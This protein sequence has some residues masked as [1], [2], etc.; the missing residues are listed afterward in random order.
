MS[1]D[2]PPAKDRKLASEVLT[3]TFQFHS[4]DADLEFSP[5][6]NS[7]HNSDKH[8][9]SSRFSQNHGI[10]DRPSDYEIAYTQQLQEKVAQN[11][12]KVKQYFKKSFTWPCL[13]GTSSTIDGPWK[14]MNIV[15]DLLLRLSAMIL[16]FFLKHST[17]R[18]CYLQADKYV[19]FFFFCWSM[20]PGVVLTTNC[21][22]Y[23]TISCFQFMKCPTKH[24]SNIY[25]VW[26]KHSCKKIWLCGTLMCERKLDVKHM[27]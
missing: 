11:Y 21:K 7:T 24:S 23:D 4:P 20:A 3:P 19:S 1:I 12:K 18:K 16:R 9:S 8:K 13:L 6:A 15:G 22:M 5:P 27:F 25:N 2:S 10:L 14:S 17:N 26:T